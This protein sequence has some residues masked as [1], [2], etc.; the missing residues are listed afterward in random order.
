M[1]RFIFDGGLVSYSVGYAITVYRNPLTVQ[2]LGEV[3]RTWEGLHPHRPSRE[4]IL[5]GEG[6][7][8]YYLHE[9]VNLGAGKTMFRHVCEDEQVQEGLREMRVVWDV[10]EKVVKVSSDGASRWREWLR[11]GRGDN[12][13]DKGEHRA[14]SRSGHELDRAQRRQRRIR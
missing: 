12:M 10:S 6:K 4:A 3:E 2:Q 14:E 7:R 8:T 9:V 11:S 1:R 5:E 13:L